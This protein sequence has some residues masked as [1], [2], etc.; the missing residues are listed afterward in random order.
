VYR[1][2]ENQLINVPSPDGM[3]EEQQWFVLEQIA[4]THGF[5]MPAL[6]DTVQAH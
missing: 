2:A 6:L 4:K 1:G 5:D 3:S